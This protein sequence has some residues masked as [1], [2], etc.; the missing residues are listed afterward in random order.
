MTPQ[1]IFTL[2]VT[3][4]VAQGKKSVQP[5]PF[6]S[7][8]IKCLY[9][10][11]D[12]LSCAVGCLIDRELAQKWDQ[13]GAEIADVVEFYGTP[14]AQDPYWGELPSWV[15]ENVDLLQSLQRVHDYVQQDT[16]FIDVFLKRVEKVATAHNLVMPKLNDLKDGERK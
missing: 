3:A 8:S 7:D 5:S 14:A 10:G 15:R 2:S 4:T 9:A 6:P 1:E 16:V 12:G 13:L 11:P